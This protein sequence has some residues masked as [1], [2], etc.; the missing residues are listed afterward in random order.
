MACLPCAGDDCWPAAGATISA[1]F[2]LLLL[3][4]VL[5]PGVWWCEWWGSACCWNGGV[6]GEAPIPLCA[7]ACVYVRVCEIY[8]GE[9]RC[10]C[11]FLCERVKEHRERGRGAVCACF[12]VRE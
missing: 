8:R 2:A 11:M 6:W 1:R 7:C 10:V 9:G 4:L 12:Y 3:L 5:L